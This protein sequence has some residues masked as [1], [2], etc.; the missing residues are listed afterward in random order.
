MWTYAIE[1]TLTTPR[2]RLSLESIRTGKLTADRL[3]RIL[4]AQ[5]YGVSVFRER[6]TGTIYGGHMRMRTEG[7][8][9]NIKGMLRRAD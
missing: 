7:K 5:G 4:L 9:V 2:E 3:I 6:V 8:A 1:A